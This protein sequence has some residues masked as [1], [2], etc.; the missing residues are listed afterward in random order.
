[1]VWFG[2]PWWCLCQ[3]EWEGSPA[4]LENKWRV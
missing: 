2:L 3:Q 4:R 1:M